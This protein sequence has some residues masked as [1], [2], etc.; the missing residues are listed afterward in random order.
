[1]EPT[2][3]RA[4]ALLQQIQSLKKDKVEKREK[5]KEGERE[6][7][8]DKKRGEEEKRMEGRKMERKGL[9]RD[10]SIK[11]KRAAESEGGRNRKKQKRD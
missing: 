2:E 4:I 1:M 7:Y 6:K 8:R 3:R 9:L 11:A 5:K 10:G